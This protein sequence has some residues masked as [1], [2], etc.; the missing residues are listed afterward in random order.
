MPGYR[1]VVHKEGAGY[2][3]GTVTPGGPTHLEPSDRPKS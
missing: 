3:A 2:L 1:E